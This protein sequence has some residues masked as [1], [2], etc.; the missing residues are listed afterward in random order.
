MHSGGQ[1]GLR[2]ISQV[3]LDKV[4]KQGQI[5]PVSPNQVQWNLALSA[6]R[7]DQECWDRLSLF[8]FT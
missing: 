4:G 2:W 6:R 1:S 7:W 3:C 5:V 8:P